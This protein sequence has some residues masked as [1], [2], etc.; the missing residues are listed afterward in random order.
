MVKEDGRGG[1]AYIMPGMKHVIKADKDQ[2]GD[3]LA[4]EDIEQLEWDW[5][6]E[7]LS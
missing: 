2:V 1:T 7:G 4:E 3:E 6:R 5:S